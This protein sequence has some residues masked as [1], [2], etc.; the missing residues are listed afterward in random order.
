MQFEEDEARFSPDGLTEEVIDA[1][2][3]AVDDEL[4]EMPSPTSRLVDG[5]AW[6][7]WGRRYVER[8]LSSTVRV[9]AVSDMVS[10][11]AGTEAA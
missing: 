8:T 3:S 7:R 1:L 10:A 4:A 2:I 11:A 6:N 5:P 9:L